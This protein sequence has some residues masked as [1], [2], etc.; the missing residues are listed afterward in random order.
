MVAPKKEKLK[1]AEADLKVAMDDLETKRADLRSVQKKLADLQ[2]SFK[3]NNTKKMQ[4]E[5]DVDL[6][7][8]KLNRQVNE[9]NDELFFRFLFPAGRNS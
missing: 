3:E 2:D 5:S 7:S 8:K 9:W 1:L 4:L 6:C